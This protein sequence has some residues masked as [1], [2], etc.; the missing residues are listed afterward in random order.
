VDA[1]GLGTGSEAEQRILNACMAGKITDLSAGA[2]SEQVVRAQFLLAVLTDSID[3]LH[4]RGLQVRGARIVGDF[5]WDW[6]RLEAPLALI[7]C[8]I[9]EPVIL[10]SANLIGLT[11]RGCRVPRL[12]GQELHST[13]TIDLTG[14]KIPAGVDLSG[15][16]IRGRLYAHGACFGSAG[17]SNDALYL[18]NAEITGDVFL[19]DGFTAN[20]STRLVGARIGGDLN[21]DGMFSNPGREALFFDRAEVTGDVYLGATQR[22]HFSAVGEVRFLGASIGGMFVCSGGDFGNPGGNALFLDGASIAGDVFLHEGF[23]A[24]GTVR[25]P[26]AQ[27]G[28]DLVCT[29]GRFSKPDGNALDFDRAQINGNVFL[30]ATGVNGTVRLLGARIGG[31]LDCVGAVFNSGSNDFALVMEGATIAGPFR[32]RDLPATPT[33]AIILTRATVGELNDDSAAWPIAGKLLITGFTYSRFAD[34]A[35][36]T[37]EERLDWIRRQPVYSSQ[38]YQQLA[39]TYRQGGNLREARTVAVAR[40]DD[41]RTRG[42]LTRLQRAWNRFLGV[43]I[44]HGYRPQR[45]AWALLALFVLT[46]IPVRVGARNDAFVQVGNSPKTSVTSSHCQTGYPCFSWPAYSLEDITPILNLHQ[47]EN[48]QADRSRPWGWLLGDWLYVA[49]ILG[50][51][52][53]TLLVAAVTGLARSD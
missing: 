35:P 44:G 40:H 15:A 16:H 26:G 33:G 50:W 52:G 27:I 45:A 13:H 47:A 3:V 42:D 51:A 31:G 25:L 32:W 28:G 23:H 2:A 11:L 29:D 38:P 18:D 6:Q 4:P 8:V 19:V 37:P 5:A 46:A 20:G 43:T 39:S 53:T 1:P 41:L 30:R 21:C 14:S 24:S 36:S 49:N 17:H 34:N 9:E 22:P 48:W 7:E 10:A 12:G